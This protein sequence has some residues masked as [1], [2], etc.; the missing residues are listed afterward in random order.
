MNQI[1][2]LA[3]RSRMPV[4][5]RFRDLFHSPDRLTQPGPELVVDQCVLLL[6]TV[7]GGH[8]DTRIPVPQLGVVRELS[9]HITNPHSPSQ[10][11]QP[12]LKLMKTSLRRHVPSGRGCWRHSLLAYTSPNFRHQRRWVS[13][14]T[15]T[16]PSSISSSTSRKLSGH[17]QNSHTQCEV[18]STGYRCHLHE[19][20]APTDDPCPP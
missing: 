1:Q 10:I 14:E 11:L 4:L 2:Y 18:T 15:T 16:P 9:K 8:L 7:D 17:R 6:H 3:V 12:P 19:G 5:L 13:R 20:G